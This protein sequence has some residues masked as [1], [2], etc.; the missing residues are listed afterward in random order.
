MKM[1]DPIA[2]VAAV[3]RRRCASILGHG[4]S[5]IRQAVIRAE[6]LSTELAFAIWRMV[7]SSQGV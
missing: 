4:V 7:S 5:P 2:L 3:Q 1:G 6:A